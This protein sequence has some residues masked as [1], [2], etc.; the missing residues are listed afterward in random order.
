MPLWKQQ[1]AAYKKSFT[2]RIS[3]Q[4][5]HDLHTPRKKDRRDVPFSTH[6]N[7]CKEPKTSEILHDEHD[8]NFCVHAKDGF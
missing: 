8:E 5:P 3:E 2:L 6:Y 1:K 7:F 4:Q